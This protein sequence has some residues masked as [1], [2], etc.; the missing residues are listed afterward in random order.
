M[1]TPQT[2]TNPDN[3]TTKTARPHPVRRSKRWY[4]LAV[5]TGAFAAIIYLGA[6]AHLG[7]FQAPSESE[8]TTPA[9][10][11]ELSRTGTIVLQTDPDQCAQMKFDNANGRFTDGLKPCDNQ[12]QFDAHGR[13]IPMGTIH[14]LDAISRSFFGR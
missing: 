4:G 10:N 8:H 6:S 9:A 14:R 7:R 3:P 5:I 1:R 12:I 11:S 2:R 13:P